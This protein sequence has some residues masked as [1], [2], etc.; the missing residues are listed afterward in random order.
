MKRTRT[1]LTLYSLAGPLALLPLMS[2][3]FSEVGDYFRGAEFRNIAVELIAQLLAG[4]AQSI[5][6][7]FTQAA[8]GVF[9]A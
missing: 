6:T 2:F 9:G 8:F 7:L 1:T 4:L 3:S 5:I